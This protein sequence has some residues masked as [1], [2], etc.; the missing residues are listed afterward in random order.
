MAAP[1]FHVAPQFG[2]GQAT[3]DPASAPHWCLAVWRLGLPITWDRGAR[4]SASRDS[5]EG[6]KLRS[7]GPLVVADDCVHLSVQ[8]QKASHVKS[9]TATLQ[10]SDT[11]YLLE[12]LP[13]DWVA[14][15]MVQG[16]DVLQNLITRLK[17]GEACNNFDDGLKFVGRAEDVFV[18]DD[19]EPG[20]VRTTRYSLRAYGFREFD[21]RVFYDHHLASKTF[22]E[23]A[24]PADWLGRIGLDIHKYFTL[25][26]EDVREMEDNC[27]RLIPIFVEIMLGRGVAETVNPDIQE[28]EDARRLRAFHGGGPAGDKSAP[29][30]Y[31]AP[32]EVG[33][34]LGRRSRDD[35]RG[36]AVLAYADLLDVVVGVQTYEA[37]GQDQDWRQLVPK[38]DYGNDLTNGNQLYTGDPLMGAFL[39]NA[40]DFMDRPIWSILQQFL[41]PEVNEMYT[42]LKVGDSGKIVPQLVLRQIP[43]TTEVLADKF[44]NLGGADLGNS[45]LTPGSTPKGDRFDELVQ[46]ARTK[47]TPFMSLP[48]WVLAP[49]LVRRVQVG[50][51]DATR[52]NFVHV[53]GIDA[54]SGHPAQQQYIFQLVQNPPLED[55]LDIQRSGLH[56][57]M[58]TTA[59]RILDQ[60]GHVPSTWME[61]IADYRMGSHLT[62]S[63][64]IQCAV[65][66]QA[67]V[68]EG[69]NLEFD[70]VVYHI[71]GVADTASI[72]PDGRRT[73]TTS[74]QVSNGLRR[75]DSEVQVSRAKPQP[76]QDRGDPLLQD[77]QDTKKFPSYAGVDARDTPGAD[78]P[79]SGDS[80][81]DK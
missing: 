12:I 18:D 44:Q 78:A 19:R 3:D 22:S 56:T 51:S 63:G 9:L 39:P 67:P 52:T 80:G 64:S 41:N 57:H 68:A 61:L 24:S 70:G 45:A 59:C 17:R 74:F 33:K 65:G 49:S 6:V 2:P 42:V 77:K 13:G 30:A 46:R 23:N 10:H 43:F 34:A 71:E 40:V 48:R 8:R 27:H 4:A 76:P 11:N 66:I 21:T 31:L 28:E 36:A 55:G 26:N 15:W 69:D 62:L 38:I 16:R 81:L 60:A 25:N 1:R 37:A 73:W 50:R 72:G 75:P 5:T 35:R 20:G 29:F 79:A 7:P 58:S 14:A 53:Y 54:N 47:V 32:T